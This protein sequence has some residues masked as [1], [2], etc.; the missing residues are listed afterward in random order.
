MEKEEI[1]NLPTID[2]TRLI[3]G[4]P[5]KLI[6]REHR[7]FIKTNYAFYLEQKKAGKSLS[8]K[9]MRR[10]YGE[11]GQPSKQFQVY[12][13]VLA[14]WKDIKDIWS[15][16]YVE[17]MDKQGNVVLKANGKPEMTRLFDIKKE[18]A[19][20]FKEPQQVEYLNKDIKST[21]VKD[22]TEI[23]V[24]MSPSQVQK[25]EDLFEDPR[26]KETDFYQLNYDVEAELANRYKFVF[27][28]SAE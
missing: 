22:H 8:P 28:S 23:K 6:S 26:N 17:T 3:A 27:N 10:K 11:D 2:D 1:Q 7:E 15:E 14:E 9:L 20:C 12:D 25:I 24:R 21:V 19:I 5:F 4:K 16:Y 13:K 18:V